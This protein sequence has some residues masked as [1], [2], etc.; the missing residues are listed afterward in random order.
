MC[1]EMKQEIEK[2]SVGE[3]VSIFV[4]TKNYEE[5]EEISL[6]ISE[7][8]DKDL[9]KGV[10]KIKVTGKITADGTAELRE[11]LEIEHV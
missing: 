2:A 5:G 4:T 9:T 3:K 7:I 11:E 8:D 10:K 6:E 1:A